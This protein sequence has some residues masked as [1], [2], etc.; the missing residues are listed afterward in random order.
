MDT[1]S[2]PAFVGEIALMLGLVIKGAKPAAQDVVALS[3]AAVG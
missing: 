1:Y 3:S 2:Q